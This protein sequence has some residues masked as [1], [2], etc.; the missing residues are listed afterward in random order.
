LPCQSA[1]LSYPRELQENTLFCAEGYTYVREKTNKND[2]PEIDSWHKYVGIPEG[3]PY[4]ASF[5]ISMYA[6][7]NYYE[8]SPLPKIARVSAMYKAAQKN[9]Y[10]YKVIPAVRVKQ[11]ID[12]LQPADLP[13]WAHGTTAGN[14]NGHVGLVTEQVDYQTFKTIEANTGP[15]AEGSQREGNGVYHRIRKLD[16]GR[17]FQVVGFIRVK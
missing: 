3:N 15:G 6:C 7:G 14:F 12:K 17:T 1:S 4:C 13:A 2:S 9:P 16:I 10:K 5:V 8:S 11:K